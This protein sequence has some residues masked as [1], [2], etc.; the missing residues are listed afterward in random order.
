MWLKPFEI[1]ND[2]NRQLK[3]TEMKP[4]IFFVVTLLYCRS[5]Q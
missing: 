4:F 5:L 1:A 2:F 3:Q